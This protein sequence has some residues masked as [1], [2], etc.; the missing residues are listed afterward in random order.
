MTTSRSN[1]FHAF[2]NPA[3][4]LES[5]PRA[6]TRD[7]WVCTIANNLGVLG[8]PLV[9]VM[10]VTPTKSR[11]A[12]LQKLATRS[13]VSHECKNDTADTGVTVSADDPVNALG[14]GFHGLTASVIGVVSASE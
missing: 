2:A 7:G 11:L 6:T 14:S 4:A 13:R 1:D 10:H 12:P 3:A 8:S 9:T 5:R